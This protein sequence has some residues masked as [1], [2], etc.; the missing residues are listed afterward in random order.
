MADHL[1]PESTWAAPR[2]R[3]SSPMGTTRSSGRRGTRRPRTAARTAS[4]RRSSNPCARPPSRRAPSVSALRGIGIGSPGSVDY[5]GGHRCPCDQRRP[6]VDRC[7]SIGGQRLADAAGVFVGLGNDVRVG[8]WAEH[9]LGAGRP[10]RSLLGVFWGTGVGG[11]I[12]LDGSPWTGRGAAGEIGHMVVRRGGARCTCG[13]LGCVEAYAGRRAMEIEARN[14]VDNGA[15]TDLF[16][17][18]QKHG[19]EWLSSGIWDR[20]LARRTSSRASWSSG[21]L[22][23]LG[24]GIA[25]VINLLDVEAV[26]I[27]GGLGTRLGEP[28]VERIARLCC[29]ICSCPSGRPPCTSQ[30]SGRPGGRDRRRPTCEGDLM[31]LGYTVRCTS[32]RSTTAASFQTKLFGIAGDADAEADRERIAEAKS[33]DLR[34]PVRAWLED[35]AHRRSPGALAD[36]QFG[37]AVGPAARASAGIDAGHAGREE[38]RSTSSTSSSARS[39]APHPGAR[40]RL[41]EGARP[42]QPGRR[43]E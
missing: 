6:G 38:R 27:G 23:A 5:G 42:L 18:M 17:I 34:R 16:K 30:C 35:A 7:I 37:A 26:I 32:S 43:R 41:R 4:P 31:K 39:S 12:I 9:V 15:H 1:P 14:R 8:T 2:S 21:P 19:R 36:E 20:A 13:R 10:F 28:Y 40:P 29:P 11:G 22:R 24:A 33:I 25:S 3:R